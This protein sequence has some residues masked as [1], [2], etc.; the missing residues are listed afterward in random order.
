MENNPTAAA[1]PEHWQLP[2]RVEA[3]RSHRSDH[4]NRNTN[5][6]GRSPRPDTTI[7][8]TNPKNP[9]QQEQWRCNDY[10]TSHGC[11]DDA[12]VPRDY[13][14]RRQIQGFR[15]ASYAI[16]LLFEGQVCACWLHSA[17]TSCSHAALHHPAWMQYLLWPLPCVDGGDRDWCP[18]NHG[19]AHR[20]CDS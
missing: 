15:P 9:R 10:A 8:H 18:N 11:G 7:H 4:Y 14:G 17:V 19:A 20:I 3:H 16:S 13:A 2:R 5:N 1:L 12:S 6:T